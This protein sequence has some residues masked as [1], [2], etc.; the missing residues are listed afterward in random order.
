MVMKLL[1]VL[2]VALI[3]LVVRNKSFLPQRTQST[4]QGTKGQSNYSLYLKV[5][6]FENNL[7]IIYGIT[8]SAASCKKRLTKNH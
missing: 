5:K 1:C 2:R 3:P 8:E 4:H 7:I 6:D